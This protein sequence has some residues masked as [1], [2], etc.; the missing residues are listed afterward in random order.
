LYRQFSVGVI[1]TRAN[2][3]L[4]P[5]R[6]HGGEVGVRVAPT[7]ASTMRATWYDN[8]IKNPVSNVTIGMNLQQRQ[9]LGRTRVDGLQLDGDYRLGTSWK[10]SAGY[11]FNRA[12]VVEFAANPALANNC[13]GA[14]A[15]GVTGSPAA[16]AGPAASGI[17][18]GLVMEAFS[19]ALSIRRSAASSTTTRT[20]ASCR[21][22]R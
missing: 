1:T 19:A 11:L 15:A 9:N 18:P 12:R 14:V 22:R 20:R 7:R 2:D 3:Q 13:P 21:S 17:R 10:V 16:A 8:R 6:L 5:E 4:G